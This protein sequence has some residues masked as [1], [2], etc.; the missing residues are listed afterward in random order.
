MKVRSKE[1]SFGLIHCCFKS[2]N[3]F[4]KTS[5]LNSIKS[6]IISF[7]HRNSQ[8]LRKS[9]ISFHL[10]PVSERYL[11]FKISIPRL[12]PSL[13]N[14]LILYSSSIEIRKSISFLHR[15]NNSSVASTSC[16]LY[17]KT[18]SIFEVGNQS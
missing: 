4:C 12:T 9:L 10:R 11:C 16:L 7:K 2:V 15:Y 18:S 6:K 3:K 17:S 5:V 13:F 8:G 1:L 14:A